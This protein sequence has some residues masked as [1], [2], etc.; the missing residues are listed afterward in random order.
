MMMRGVE[1]QNFVMTT[2]CMPGSV[3]SQPQTRNEFLGLI[4]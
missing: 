1:N 3:R 2:S 4:A